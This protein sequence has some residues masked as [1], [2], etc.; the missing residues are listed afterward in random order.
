MDS[1]RTPSFPLPKDDKS[2]GKGNSTTDSG[3]VTLG[4]KLNTVEGKKYQLESDV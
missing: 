3:V 2:L 1:M 4:I